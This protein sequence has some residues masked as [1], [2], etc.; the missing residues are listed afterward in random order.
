[1]HTATQLYRESFTMTVRGHPATIDDVF[2][3]WTSADRFGIVI[4]RPLGAL[5]ASL[6]I[7]V[8]IAAFYEA[9]PSRRNVAP[10]YPEVYAFHL[11][12]PMGDHS[13]FDFWPPRKEMVVPAEPVSLLATVNAHAITRLALP[14]GQLGGVAVLENGPS[15]WAEQRS[16]HDRLLTCLLYDAGGVVNDADVTLSSHDP[17]AEENATYTF[18]GAMSA[19]A[20][21]AARRDV[22]PG[23][24]SGPGPSRVEDTIRWARNVT[25]RANEVSDGERQLLRRDRAASYAAHQGRVEQYRRLSVDDALARIAGLC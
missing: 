4:D 3:E 1:M 5:G 11:G 6:L 18:E 14:A 24:A 8:A 9:R 13:A 17:R 10:V 12:R 20:A 2:P 21:L 19:E 16:A 22:P 23:T 7:E 15:T 25:A